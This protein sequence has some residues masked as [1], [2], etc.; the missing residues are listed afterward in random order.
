[1]VD[2]WSNGVLEYW[3]SGNHPVCHSPS[4]ISHFRS[5]VAPHLVAHSP[6]NLAMSYEFLTNP[7]RSDNII[8]KIGA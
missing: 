1:V 2:R 7:V 5:G 3:S 8:R 6:I 4:T